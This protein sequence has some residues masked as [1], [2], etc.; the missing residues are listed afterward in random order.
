MIPGEE[1]K[2]AAGYLFSKSRIGQD[3]MQRLINMLRDLAILVR[4]N[5]WIVPV[6]AGLVFALFYF[7]A[8]PAPMTATMA[9]GVADGGYVAFANK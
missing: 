5:L 3:T 7:V 6:L 4:A 2:R 8:P 9:T 1:S